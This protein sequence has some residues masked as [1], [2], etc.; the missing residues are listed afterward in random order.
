[1]DSFTHEEYI[2]AMKMSGREVRVTP[3]TLLRSQQ[4]K[5]R[6]NPSLLARQWAMDVE[7]EEVESELKV[8]EAAKKTQRELLV[9]QG[10]VSSAVLKYSVSCD[11]STVNHNSSINPPSST[12]AASKTSTLADPSQ[13]SVATADPQGSAPL[14]TALST[15]TDRHLVDCAPPDD[16]TNSSVT[17]HLLPPAQAASTVTVTPADSSHHSPVTADPQDSAS[18]ASAPSASTE[19]QQDSPQQAPVVEDGLSAQHPEVPT[20][21]AKT[22]ES[23]LDP[24]SSRCVGEAE[25][26]VV[27]VH[28]VGNVDP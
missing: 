10:L 5:T 1:M 27:S 14:A 11:A 28:W 4:K 3:E 24:G 18:V 8:R 9:A 6:T 12:Q 16:D 13:H 26:V 19:R 22:A 23:V 17:T 21:S 15:S 20:S 25:T 2:A 7:A